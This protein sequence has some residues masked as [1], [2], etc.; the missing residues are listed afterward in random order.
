MY[1]LVI[2]KYVSDGTLGAN[3]PNTDKCF[4]VNNVMAPDG[5]ARWEWIKEIHAFS[6]TLNAVTSTLSWADFVK[7]TSVTT[8]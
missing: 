1:C 7:P 3:S 5:V 6:G 2:L 4:D 8:T